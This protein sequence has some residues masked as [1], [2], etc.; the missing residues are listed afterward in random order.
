MF[1][2]G[3]GHGTQV[4]SCTNATKVA[5]SELVFRSARTSSDAGAGVHI[6][7]TEPSDGN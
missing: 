6:V 1:V 2:A 5:M 4:E 7:Q 3:K